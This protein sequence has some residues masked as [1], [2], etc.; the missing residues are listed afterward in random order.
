MNEI[1]TSPTPTQRAI[2][3][4][5]QQHWLSLAL[6]SL[7][8]ALML[9]LTDPLARALMLSHFGFFLLW[10]PL[11]R[12]GQK[13]VPGQVGLIIAAAALLI[14][15]ASY[16]MMALWISVLFSLIGGNVPGIKNFGQR[17]VSLL[18]AIYLL[19]VLLTWVV[20]HLFLDLAFPDAFHALVR[21][22]IVIPALA[23]FF[24]RTEKLQAASANS[25]DLFYSLLLF[26]MVVVIVLGAFA[27]KQVSHGNYIISLAQAL[28]VAAGLLVALS[29]LWDPR[30]GFSG[31][32][33]LV[34]RY[35]LSIGVP[36]ERWMHG[37]AAL[38]ERERDPDKFVIVAAT[39]M[40][41]TLAQFAGKGVT[42]ECPTAPSLSAPSTCAR[43]P[44]PASSSGRGK[45]PDQRTDLPP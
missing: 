40:P 21:Y 41:L 29:L 43:N 2:A 10:Q 45:Q 35:L 42:G 44:L 3:A 34:T 25:V 14:A 8:G 20:P 19:S 7:H 6:V 16:W 4:I 18:A 32:G 24:V 15:A 37:L 28:I 22:G 33:Q 9:D 39:A 30:A 1:A 36:F 38:A 27:I 5:R 12:G 31:I 13:L 17:V 26:L 11:W 23:I